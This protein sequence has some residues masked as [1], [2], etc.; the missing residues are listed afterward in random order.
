[1]KQTHRYREQINGYE[2]RRENKGARE[3]E[4]KG[5]LCNYMRLYV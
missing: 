5:Y 3:Q 1:M 2:W 4:E